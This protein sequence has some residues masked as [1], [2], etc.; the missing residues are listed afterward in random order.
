MARN[1][2]L[3]IVPIQQTKNL[4]IKQNN[5]IVIMTVIFV[6]NLVTRTFEQKKLNIFQAIAQS[7]KDNMKQTIS[8][9]EHLTKDNE[10]ML[11]LAYDN[12]IRFTY[13]KGN[14]GHGKLLSI[15]NSVTVAWLLII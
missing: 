3:R 9:N 15:V 5:E 4:R 13:I 10:Y 11:I 2:I 12:Y 1:V 14:V 6:I 7:I 8:P